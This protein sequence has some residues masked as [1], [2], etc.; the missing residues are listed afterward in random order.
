MKSLC[1]A[2]AAIAVGVMSAAALARTQVQAHVI[3]T[4]ATEV[5]ASLTQYEC[6]AAEGRIGIP[7]AGDWE[8]GAGTPGSSNTSWGT[9]HTTWTGQGVPFT[10]SHTRVGNT[11]QFSWSI[12]GMTGAPIEG[13]IDAIVNKLVIRV[14]V[15]AKDANSTATGFLRDVQFNGYG[16]TNLTNPFGDTVGLGEAAKRRYALVSLEDP[17]LNWTLTGNVLFAWEGAMPT[18]S[19][20]AFQIKGLCCPM[21]PLPGAGLMGLAGLGAVASIRRRKL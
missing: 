8:V 21:V 20:L 3:E 10:L 15:G 5:P 2:A 11:S 4:A 9:R 6:F 13:A 18:R 7:G 1:Y 12:A 17:T 14:R 19:N 16:I